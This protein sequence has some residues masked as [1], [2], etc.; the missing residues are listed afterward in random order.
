[1]LEKAEEW[2][3]MHEAQFEKIKYLLVYFT[4]S[5]TW[6]ISALIEITETII[7]S[8]NE[9]RYLRVIFDK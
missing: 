2:R 3:K 4:R 8:T 5:K 7:K 6:S 1:M 9:A